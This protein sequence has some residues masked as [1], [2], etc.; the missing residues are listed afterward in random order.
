[1]SGRGIP[2][3]HRF[4]FHIYFENP[5][6]VCLFPFRYSSPFV[7]LGFEPSLGATDDSRMVRLNG[8]LQ[9]LYLL[10]L[11]FQ[12]FDQPYTVLLSLGYT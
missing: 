12:G 10:E 9:F 4:L 5:L 3:V 1:V 2:G 7:I 8:G 6:L 11:P